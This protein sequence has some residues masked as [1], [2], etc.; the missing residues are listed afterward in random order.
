MPASEQISR[1]A[2]YAQRLLDDDYLQDEFGRLFT[3]LRDGSRRVRKTGPAQATTDR[4]LRNQFAAALAAATHIGRA[5]KQPEPEPP[6]GHRLRTLALTVVIAGGAYA[7]YRQLT[8]SGPEPGASST[9]SSTA[10]V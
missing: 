8:A 3:N 7:G 4:Q 5:L 10:G 6:K 1:V 9:P 2:P